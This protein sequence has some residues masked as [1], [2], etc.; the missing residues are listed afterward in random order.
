[1]V[2]GLGLWFLFLVYLLTNDAIMN[3]QMNL[4]Q[5]TVNESVRSRRLGLLG[6]EGKG[7]RF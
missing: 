5:C 6:P 1:M 3:A 7:W 2:Y 4:G